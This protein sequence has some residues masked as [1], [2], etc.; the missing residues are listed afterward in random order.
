M[1]MPSPS[2]SPLLLFAI[3]AACATAPPRTADS[4]LDL[5][6]P[7]RWSAPVDAAAD[8]PTGAWWSGFGDARLDATVEAALRDNRDLRAALARLEAAASN[9]TIAG[10]AGLPQ[11]DA[12][13][14]PQRARRLFLGFPFGGGG[15]PSSTTTTFGLSLSLR[16]E[17]D[18]WGRVAAGES[19]AIGDLQA[20]A[21]DVAGARTS[22]TAQVCK[23]WFAVVAAQRQLELAE[24]TIDAFRG[25]A[26]DVRDRY[27]RGMRPAI[28]VHQAAANLANAEANAAARRDELQRARH[29]LDVLAGRSPGGF[30]QATADLPASLPTVPA[31]LPGDLLQRRPDLVAAERRLAAAGCRVDSARAALYPRLSL[32]GSAGTTSQELEDLV[33]EDFRV[34]SI[35]ANLLQPLL[36]GGALRAE[37]ARAQALRAEALANYGGAVLRAFA[38]VEDALAS[39][40][41]LDQRLATVTQA[42]E[43]AAKARDLARE[44]WQLGLTDFLAVA[45]G[46]RQAYVAMATRIDVERQRI[47][48]RIDLF[49]ALGGGF[50]TAGDAAPEHGARP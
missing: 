4:E 49:L 32:T 24:G 29:R 20:V 46:Q 3:V 21:A 31:G 37:V 25:T 5:D 19:A 50:P 1:N 2:R 9:R 36:R 12:S 48:N 6:V 33:D 16:W 13:F 17:L 11:L 47:D 15:V 42:A 38:E 26:D 14:D 39:E 43:H 27:R 40:R 8:A 23:A 34:W 22:L 45:D 18:L 35:G 44:R 28:D 10:A 30:A 7:D 41:L